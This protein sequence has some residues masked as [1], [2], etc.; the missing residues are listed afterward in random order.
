MFTLEAFMIQGSIVCINSEM[1]INLLYYNSGINQSFSDYKI[2]KFTVQK[3]KKLDTCLKKIFKSLKINLNL[4]NKTFLKNY[5]KI[6]L[7]DFFR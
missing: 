4:K 1:F 2:S 6:K 5:S 3:H 7:L